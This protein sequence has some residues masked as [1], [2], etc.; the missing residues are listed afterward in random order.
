MKEWEEKAKKEYGEEL[1]RSLYPYRQWIKDNEPL[2]GGDMSLMDHFALVYYEKGIPDYLPDKDYII[3]H[4]EY[5]K[6]PGIAIA[7]MYEVF[8]ND[9]DVNIIYGD[10]DVELQKGERTSPWFKPDWSPDTYESLPYFGS[11]VAMRKSFIKDKLNQLRDPYDLDAVLEVL[12]RTTRPYHLDM[13]V[14]NGPAEI[15]DAEEKHIVPD[16]PG[17]KPVKVSIIIPSKDHPDMLERCL[18][19]ITS[20]TDYPDMELLI[21]DNGSTDE[22]RKLYEEMKDVYHYEYIYERMQFNFSRMCNIGARRAN[23]EVL[24]FLNDDT[25]VISRDWLSIMAAVA[26]QSHVGAV[27]AKLYYPYVRGETPRIQ[28]AGITNTILG[29]VHKMGGCPDEGSIYHGMNLCDRDVIAVT[30]ACLAVE[31]TKFNAVGGFFEELVVAYN[32]V[33][34]CFSLYEKGWLNVQR[35]DAILIHHE[36]VSRGSDES[37]ARKTRRMWE[38]LE[39]YKR[40]PQLYGRDPFYNRNLVQTRLDVDYNV[41]SLSDHEKK[42]AVSKVNEISIPAETPGGKI[43]RRLGLDINPQYCIDS[44]DVYYEFADDG[45]YHRQWKI[46]GWMAPMKQPLWEYERKLLL[47]TEEGIAHLVDV[48]SKY[49]PDVK[50]V[51]KDQQGADM[52]GFVA[53]ISTDDLGDGDYRIGLYFVSKKNG[54]IFVRYTDTFMK[55]K[56]GDMPL[57]RKEERA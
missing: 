24:L 16:F 42:G 21:I 43:R 29:P 5:G 12:V 35:N 14:Y 10:E 28:H 39:L 15:K 38:W 40:H 17:R 44:A 50:T 13:I 1:N 20:L 48:F 3:F 47:I 19:G 53:R 55:V 36:S 32:D 18:I 6:V 25:E 34:L 26:M 57:L 46:E 52:A 23:G 7:K 41:N 49:R 54:K 31:K 33:D 56:E 11:L 2:A 22:N 8:K 45:S 27:G 4:K 37:D 51:L 9:P 30:G